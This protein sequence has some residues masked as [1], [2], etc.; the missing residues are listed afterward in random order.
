MASLNPQLVAVAKEVIL[1]DLAALQRAPDRSGL[2]AEAL[3]EV[4][5]Y[6]TRLGSPSAETGVRAAPSQTEGPPR[7]AHEDAATTQ[8]RQEASPGDGAAMGQQQDD[9]STL[10]A[11]QELIARLIRKLLGEPA[12]HTYQEQNMAE[13]PQDRFVGRYEGEHESQVATMA[14]AMEIA[15]SGNSVLRDLYERGQLGNTRGVVEYAESIHQSANAEGAGKSV[16]EAEETTQEAGRGTANFPSMSESASLRSETWDSSSSHGLG[17]GDTFGSASRFDSNS[18]SA[19]EDD[20]P[21]T[22][23]RASAA[24]LSSPAGAAP[25]LTPGQATSEPVSTTAAAAAS[26]SNG[27]HQLPSGPL[28]RPATAQSHSSPVLQPQTPRS[29][30][31]RQ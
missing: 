9:T 10:S 27:V 16:G 29:T 18:R 15:L 31:P 11:V 17:S 12:P 6:V 19:V 7:A 4:R 30:S 24:R 20:I 23:S 28:H 1:Q 2:S 3:E 13:R 8:G 14:Q 26:R 25:N 21:L 22:R 5:D